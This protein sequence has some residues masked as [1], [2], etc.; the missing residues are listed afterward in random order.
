LMP[1]QP[2]DERLTH[3]LPLPFLQSF[4]TEISCHCC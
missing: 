3:Q 2:F 1:F 4:W